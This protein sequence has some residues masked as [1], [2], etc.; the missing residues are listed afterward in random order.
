MYKYR[1]E[2]GPGK[3][4]STQQTAADTADAGK[5]ASHATDSSRLIMRTAKKLVEEAQTKALQLESARRT[6][7]ALKP[8]ANRA[9]ANAADDIRSS[10]LGTVLAQY[11]EAQ[12]AWAQE[13]VG[14]YDRQQR[15]SS[16]QL[17]CV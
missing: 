15:C 8:V 12:A 10:P 4:G 6:A 1:S 3:H 16:V 11:K 14:A 7:P 5:R 9:A 2:A 17:L 13:K